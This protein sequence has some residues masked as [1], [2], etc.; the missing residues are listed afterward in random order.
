MQRC[1]ACGAPRDAHA[2]LFCSYCGKHQNVG[3]PRLLEALV[4]EVRDGKTSPIIP[5]GARLPTSYSD[6]F[7]TASDNQPTVE[8]HL[9]VGN[10][11]NAGE[12]RSLL[13]IAHPII[14]RAP[15]GVPK[16][17]LTVS[18]T[19]EGHLSVR[20]VELGTDNIFEH[21]GLL[22]AVSSAKL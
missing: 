8:I 3:S 21:R 6:T 11:D 17:Q 4:I 2:G 5:Y 16:L 19:A 13:R 1:N 18:L 7:S 22:I 9:M 10:S 12:N 15:T 14:A 20:M